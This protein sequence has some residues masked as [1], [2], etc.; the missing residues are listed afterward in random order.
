MDCIYTIGVFKMDLDL[1]R[2]SL[3]IQ[4]AGQADLVLDLTEIKRIEA[5]EHELT[6]VNK[7]T[8]YELMH[9]FNQGSDLINKY[10][11]LIRFEHDKTITKANQRKSIVILDIAHEKLKE[12]GFITTRSPTGSE[13]LRRA[14][15]EGDPEYIELMERIDGLKALHQYFKDKADKFKRNYYAARKPLDK[16]DVDNSLHSLHDS[17]GEP[18]L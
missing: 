13:D 5:R 1:E 4:R 3:S 6:Y 12:K 8:A 9:T 2:P 10:I 15:L 16:T 11:T 17:I 18:I 14:V 7:E